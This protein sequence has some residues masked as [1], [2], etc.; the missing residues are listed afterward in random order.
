MT[1]FGMLLL[2]AAAPG[3]AFAENCSTIK[4][5]EAHNSLLP[6]V[7]IGT[8]ARYDVLPCASLTIDV[9]EYL[10][11]RDDGRP[12]ANFLMLQVRDRSNRLEIQR[13]FAAHENTLVISLESATPAPLPG[14]APRF[15]KG[16]SLMIV[17]GHRTPERFSSYTMS[18]G[19]VADGD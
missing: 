11:A 2:I 7:G 16:Q 19:V 18:A 9:S 17:V 15:V 8:K 6:A 14:S 3:A 13:P 5:D 4:L 10:T 12:P 1:R